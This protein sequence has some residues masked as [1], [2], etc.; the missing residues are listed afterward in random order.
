MKAECTNQQTFQLSENNQTL[1]SLH[2][3]TIFSSDA[4]VVLPNNERY[5]IKPNGFFGTSVIITKNSTAIAELRMNM[6]GQ[7]VISFTNGE[8]YI[9]KNTSFLNNKFVIENKNTEK[10]IQYDPNLN[11]SKLNYN[12]NI[13]HNLKT[14]EPLFILIGVYAAN[15]YIAAMSGLV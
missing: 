11:W 8:E 12:Y 13:S 9:F 10:L 14:Q 3:K 15:Y 1:G 5:E 6:K 2:Y 7:I 4:E